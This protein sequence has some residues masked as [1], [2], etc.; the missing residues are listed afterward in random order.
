MAVAAYS[1]AHF[2]VDFGCAYAIF[3]IHRLSPTFFLLYNFFAFAM[4]MPLGLFADRLQ[5]NKLLAL[6][7]IAVTLLCCSIPPSGAGM[8]CMLGLGNAL[9]HIG[10]G[11]DIM[12]HS[13]EKAAPLGIF[14]SP[15]AFGVFLGTMLGKG[16]TPFFPAAA[17][18]ALAFAAVIFCAKQAPP[19][20]QPALPQPSVIAPALLLFGVVILRSFGGT[21]VQLPWKAGIYT[22]IAVAM[23]VL[24]K[25]LGG[26]LADRLGAKR[27]SFFSLLIA[28]LCFLFGRH[29]AAGL[30]GLLLFNMTM[31]I[32][33]QALAQKMPGA[34]GFSFGLLT[35][36]LFLGFLPFYL[37][38][39]GIS[40]YAMAGIAAGSAAL[41]MIGLRGGTP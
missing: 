7:G 29:A 19:P 31:P 15:G 16:C 4:Q 23:I 34:K 17:A 33:L 8:V 32:T 10:G 20:V 24:G 35:F 11:L 40:T 22:W 6:L 13:G 9:F 12:H 18:L 3:S 28:A 38:A 1:F 2:A 30:I 39:G 26:I 25:A 5:K 14:V 27:V 21:A 36:A 41:L 37:G